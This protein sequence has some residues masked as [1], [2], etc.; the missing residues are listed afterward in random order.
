MITLARKTIA[1]YKK[2]VSVAAL[3]KGSND[4]SRFLLNSIPK[5]GTNLLDSVF[6][7]MPGVARR[8]VST[9]RSWERL[10]QTTISALKRLRHGEYLL[11]HLPHSSDLVR[12]LTDHDTKVITIVRD[13][14]AVV[15]SYLNY[16]DSI[17]QRH[18]AAPFFANLDLD[19][20]VEA[21]VNGVPGVVTAI[22]VVFDKF[23][24]WDT[25]EN[26]LMVRFEDLIG[27]LGGGS[28]RQQEETING[29]FEFLSIP[30][31]W[32]IKAINQLRCNKSSPTFFK[33]Q[34][35]AWKSN[36]SSSS[37]DLLDANL[38]RHLSF[39]SYD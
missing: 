3:K 19:S 7:D 26:C 27:A 22:D 4:V 24:G 36:L 15:Y 32:K 35:D 6:L 21:L 16:L 12:C 37:R 39:F 18:P 13:P 30:P 29:I 8:Q 2:R 14:R 17:D 10:N 1:V 9:L 5:G 38:S 33:G 23:L 28:D 31:E 25:A 11:G 20:K 34:S